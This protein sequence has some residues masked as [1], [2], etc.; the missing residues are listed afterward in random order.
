MCWKENVLLPKS[1]ATIVK[2]LQDISPVYLFF[3]TDGKDTLVEVNRRNTIS[4]TNWIFNIDKRLP[5]RLVIPEIIKLQIKRKNGMHENPA[6]GNYYSYADSIGK[7]LAFLPF[8]KV[9]YKTEQPRSAVVFFSKGGEWKIDNRILNELEL[10]EYL[11]TNSNLIFGFDKNI[12]YGSYIQQKVFLESLKVE[13]NNSE[14]I[15]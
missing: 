1:N 11:K 14:F 3:R 7:N 10:R 15:Y 5:L 9:N 2:D 6:A 8:T 12:S 13:N 4:T